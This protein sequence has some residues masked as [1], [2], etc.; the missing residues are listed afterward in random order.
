MTNICKQIF[1]SGKVQGVWYRQSTKDEA[2]K[3]GV[4]GWA[5]NLSDGRV[6]V[7]VCGDAEAVA[8]LEH[9]LH[10]GPDRARVDEVITIERDYQAIEGFSTG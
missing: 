4:T 1:V 6:E 9:W 3:R 7:L 2:L 10:D 5:R 8:E